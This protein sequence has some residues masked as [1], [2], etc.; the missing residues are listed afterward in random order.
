MSRYFQ[1]LLTAAKAVKKPSSEL[2]KAIEAVEHHLD[3]P[4]RQKILELARVTLA[5]EGELE[6][7]DDAIVSEGN[8][9][10]A[11]LQAWAWVDFGGTTLDKDQSGSACSAPLSVRETEPNQQI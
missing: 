7:D 2:R 4:G 11:Y 1:D 3:G 8:D 5:R 10:G 6:F 9:N